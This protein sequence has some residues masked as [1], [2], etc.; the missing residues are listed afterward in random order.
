MNT[1][2][3]FCIG[4]VPLSYAADI[5]IPE[6]P[7][8]TVLLYVFLSENAS[9]PLASF[10]FHLELP[11]FSTVTDKG[12]DVN[13]VYI[14]LWMTTS[15]AI[16]LKCTSKGFEMFW[17]GCGS[18]TI[19]NST[20]RLIP[21]SEKHHY[22]LDVANSSYTLRQDGRIIIETSINGSPVNFRGALR[23]WGITQ[24][25]RVRNLILRDTK[26]GRT[27]AIYGATRQGRGPVGLSYINNDKQE[28][29][30]F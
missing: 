3:K 28:S 16:V 24:P 9:I 23:L 22:E 30:I 29:I 2:Q 11:D 12:S 6:T 17:A 13:V 19:R 27:A 18:Q 4:E 1:L 26:S 14:G 21:S 25:Y 15:C 7:L 10:R 5:C 20:S 8:K